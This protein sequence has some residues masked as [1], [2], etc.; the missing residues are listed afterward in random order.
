MIISF[1]PLHVCVFFTMY[2]EIKNLNIKS[3]MCVCA[4][5]VTYACKIKM[6]QNKT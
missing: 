1:K 5:F 2:L 4:G 3:P 6:I